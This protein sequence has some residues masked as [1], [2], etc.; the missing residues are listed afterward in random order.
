MTSSPQTIFSPKQKLIYL[1]KNIFINLRDIFNSSKDIHQLFALSA[2][3]L[4]VDGTDWSVLY[5]Q[6]ENP[7]VNSHKKNKSIAPNQLYHS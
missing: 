5:K 3:L 4:S 6:I 1:F 2:Q 7:N